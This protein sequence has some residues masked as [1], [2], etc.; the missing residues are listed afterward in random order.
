M[1]LLRREVESRGD[2]RTW[3]PQERG[4]EVVEIDMALTRGADH[5]REDFLGPR[6]AGRAIPATDLAIDDGGTDGVFCAP[7]G[8]VHIGGPQEGEHGRALAVEMGGEALGRRQRR[9]RV[10]EPA[11]VGEQAPMS[12]GEAMIG[13]RVRITPIAERQGVGEDDLHAARPGAPRMVGA[14]R[15]TPA[16]QMR[17]TALV[18]RGGESAIR[19][20]PVADQDTGEVRAQ[21]GGRVVK[22]APGTNRIHGG[23]WRR[24]RPQPV[25]HGADAPAGFIGTDDGTPADLGTQGPVGRGG[26]ARCAMQGLDEAARRDSEPEAVTQQRRDLLE[27]YADVLVQEHNQGH[28][29][30]PEVHIGGPQRVGRLQRMPALD[31]AAT[32]DATAD[33]HVEA[34][35]DRPHD[36]QIFLILR[37]D[38]GA[39]DRAATVRA[40]GGKRGLV[41]LIAPPW[42]GS[43]GP[44][45]VGGAGAPS[46]PSAAALGPIF[47]ERGGLTEAGAPCRIELLFQARILTLQVVALATRPRQRLAQ[48]REFFL[49]APDQVVAVLAGRARALHCHT[50]FMA[51]SWQKYKYKIVSLALLRRSTR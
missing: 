32:G 12:H 23:L 18:Q 3:R 7:V 21:D 40:G 31:A 43:S 22:T 4:E 45:P 20:P 44:T 25:Q 30:G 1:I 10:D 27:R 38:A 28:G 15:A 14:E 8:R 16:E 35:D 13:D 24:E 48:A 5:T 51:D 6:A 17:Q 49:L 39:L 33:V 2:N 19:R 42:N 11:Q 34:P 46:R 41:S 26:H 29:T 36:G 9:C 47:C 50:R 37:G